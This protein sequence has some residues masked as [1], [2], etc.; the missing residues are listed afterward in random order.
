MMVIMET[1]MLISLI[2]VLDL[3]KHWGVHMQ[4]LFKPFKPYTCTSK[5]CEVFLF[6]VE[7]FIDRPHFL[8]AK[9]KMSTLTDDENVSIKLKP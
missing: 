8:W 6:H 5:L 9:V 3:Y 1:R 7:S 4:V 2:F